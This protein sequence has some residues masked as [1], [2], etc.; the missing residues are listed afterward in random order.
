MAPHGAFEA[1]VTDGVLSGWTSGT[2]DP[3]LLLHGGPGLSDYTEGFA[4]ELAGDYTVHRYQQRGLEPSVTSGP[5]EIE[6]HVQDAVAVLDALGLDKV[7]VVGHSWGA[8]LALY[9]AVL[10]PERFLGVLCVDPLGAVGDGGE[11]DLGSNLGARLLPAARERME[12]LDQRA[13]AGEGTAAD[14]VEMLRL[15]WPS[16]FANPAAAPPMPDLDMSVDCYSQTFESIRSHLAAKTLETGLPLVTL[17]TAFLLG[18][19]S[20]IPPVH[21]HRTAALIPGSVVHEL[22]ACGH[23]VWIERPGDTVQALNGLTGSA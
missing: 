15:A 1:G 5:F 16:Y 8:H 12:L 22:D 9:L 20:P 18:A 14:A 13:L 23:M 4:Q 17:P 6:T 7:W 11:S 10:H 19:Q 21:G 2:G 3:V